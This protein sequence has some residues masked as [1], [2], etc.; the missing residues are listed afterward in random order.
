MEGGKPQSPGQP[1][2]ALTCE[3]QSDNR[4]NRIAPH[5]SQQ[6]LWGLHKKQKPT[7]PPR[8]ER[9]SSKESVLWV[10]Q[11]Q[12]EIDFGQDIL[13]NSKIDQEGMSIEFTELEWPW[14]K[15]TIIHIR[16]QFLLNI[17][18]RPAPWDKQ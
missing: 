13:Q 5:Y 11:A 6:L 16:R 8:T 9:K 2:A 17:Y 12:K 14:R 15:K 7:V 1:L 18:A 10:P 3:I 4:Y